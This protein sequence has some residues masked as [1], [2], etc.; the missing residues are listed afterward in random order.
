M[1]NIFKSLMIVVLFND[2]AKNVVWERF[3]PSFAR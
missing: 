2:L 3:L 1:K